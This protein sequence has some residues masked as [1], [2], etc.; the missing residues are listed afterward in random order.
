[1]STPGGSPPGAAARFLP[2]ALALAGAYLVDAGQ[3]SPSEIVAAVLSGALTAGLWTAVRAASPVAGD[4]PRSWPMA[5]AGRLRS[6]PAETLLDGTAFVRAAFARLTGSGTGP[7]G[8]LIEQPLPRRTGDAG[9]GD[10]ALATFGATVTPDSYVAAEDR[11]RHRLVIHR[12]VQ[13][14]PDGTQPRSGSDGAK[15]HH[16]PGKAPRN[17]PGTK[18]RGASGGAKPRGGSGRAKPRGGKTGS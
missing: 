6:A 3:G 17:K 8:R 13:T 12:L 4:L 9:A 5:L 15:P 18:R 11:H 7:C 14:D 1:M 16:E 10:R 2:A